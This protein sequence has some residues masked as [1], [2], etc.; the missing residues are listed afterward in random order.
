[1]IEEAADNIEVGDRVRIRYLDGD[2]KVLQFVI[3]RGENLP[4]SGYISD[5][6]PIA[7]AVLGA[8]EG[9]EVDILIGSYVRAALVETVEKAPLS[10]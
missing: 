6:S 5:S 4:E 3:H 2:E 8:G 1:M 10:H 7:S 9:D